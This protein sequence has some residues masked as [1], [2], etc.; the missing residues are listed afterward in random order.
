MK[1]AALGAAGGLVLGGS[2]GLTDTDVQRQISEDLQK[3][4]LASQAIPARE[5]AH[6]FIFF[7]GEAKK[8]KEL[9]LRIKEAD[10]GQS[11]S[12]IM[13]F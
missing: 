3:R 7:P 12:L 8:A 5:V 6:G 10:T 13:K 2:K 9:R 1:G 4:S 11:F